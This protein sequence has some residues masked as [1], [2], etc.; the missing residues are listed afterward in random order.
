MYDQDR[1][2]VVSE[3]FGNVIFVPE[4]EEYVKETGYSVILCR[5]RDP[6]TKGKVEAMVGTVKY[7]FLEGRTYTGIDSLNSAA[8]SWCDNV[9]NSR[10]HGVTKKIPREVFKE[11]IAE[12]IKVPYRERSFNNIR[13]VRDDYSINYR[14][15]SYYVPPELVKIGDRL[16]VEEDD[17]KL[18]FSNPEDD[19]VVYTA[20]KAASSSL[21]KR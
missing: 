1:V 15:S 21:L 9:L 13:S 12:L 20:Q 11:E 16:R 19:R 3:N 6:Q 14:G 17:E 7:G 5:P 2:F 10:I 18:V 4:F 8:L